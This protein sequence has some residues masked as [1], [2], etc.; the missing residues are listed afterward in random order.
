MENVNSLNDMLLSQDA[1]DRRNA[2]ESLGDS[3]CADSVPLLASMLADVDPGVREAALNA[4]TSIGGR[5]VAEAAA[6]LLKSESAMLRNMGVEI[7]ELIGAEAFPVIAGLLNDNDDDVVKFGVDIIANCR[8]ERAIGL[9]SALVGH[10]NPNVRASVAVCLGRLKAASAV[11]LLLRALEDPEEWVRFS[12]VEGL[13]LIH[14]R[15]ALSPLL[16]L[17]E[18]DSGLIKDAAIDAAG[19]IAPAEDASMILLKLEP[20]VKKGRIFN[21]PAV[22]ELLEKAVSPGSDFRPGADFKKTYYNM[23]ARAVEDGGRS[24]KIKALKGIALLKTHEGLE[25]VF[26]FVDSLNE[27]DEDTEDLIVDTIVSITG[28]GPLPEILKDRLSRG[29]KCLKIIVRTFGELKSAEAVPLLKELIGKA[30][31]I[32]LRAVV[33]AL[34]T[35]A[36]PGSIEVLYQSLRST[37]GH[38]RKIAARALGSLSGQTAVKSL[39]DALHAEVYRDVME[40]ITDVLAT[41]PS[42]TVKKGLC[43]LLANEKESLREMGARGLGSIGDEESLK[44]LIEASADKS[45]A[46]RKAAYKSMA[47]LGI[48]NAVDEVVKGLSDPDDEVKLSVMKGLGGWAGDQ[49]KAALISSLNDRNIWVRY[50]A[51]VLLGELGESDVESVIVDKLLKDEAPVKAAAAKALERLGAYEAIADLEQFLSHPD[52]SVRGAVESALETLRC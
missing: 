30:G 6:P 23:F 5:K 35:I 7:L 31:K 25:T 26:K 16:K 28:R 14:D 38:T 12:A 33:T 21:I 9:L 47:R 41:I 45:P 18:V 50:H 13:G 24:E 8:E 17:I 1:G 34:E 27:I 46:V 22:M 15:R 43:A 42:E 4:L 32:E 19:R 52:P 29:G 51:V 39:F 44:H 37:D 2:C 48:P 3:R 20:L 40:E 10:A 11:P 49:I 36:S